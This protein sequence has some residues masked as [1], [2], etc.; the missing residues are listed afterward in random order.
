M[1]DG[2]SP[3]Y[4]NRVITLYFS[5]QPRLAQDMAKRFLKNNYPHRDEGNFASFNMQVTPISELV[6]ECE[7]L[8][9]FSEKKC[10]VASDCF[11][12]RKGKPK[13]LSGDSLDPLVE[14]CKRPNPLIDL[15]LLVFGDDLDPKNQAVALLSKTATVKEVSEPSEQELVAYAEKK[16][17][18]QGSPF[19]SGAASLLVSRVSGDY[20]RFLT[21]FD[22]LLAYANGEEITKKAVMMLVKGELEQDAFVLSNALLKNDVSGALSCYRALKQSKVE[23]IALLS[24]LSSQFQFM[25][26]VD[27]LD[28]KGLSSYQIAMELK[29]NRYRVDM[30]LRSLSGVA[31][32]KEEEILEQIYKTSKS[33]L[34]GEQ[35]Q[36]FAF[37]RFLV[38]FA[39]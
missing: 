20:S 16:A 26:R 7:S 29:A 14:Y 35:E 18:A 21:E 4:N 27:Y 3:R 13:L 32:G 25:E 5:A 15:I 8:S 17:R 19:Q 2:L 12:L 11:F 37:E 39:L 28:R 38:N 10:I 22:K 24:L 36:G 30:T 1:Q 23:E 6:K 33:I 34:S 31:E 9:L